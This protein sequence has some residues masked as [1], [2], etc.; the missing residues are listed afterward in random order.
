MIGADGR[1]G[2]NLGEAEEAREGG[3]L[4]ALVEVGV[5]PKLQ[6]WLATVFAPGLRIP[7]P[8][9]GP[10]RSESDSESD[11]GSDSDDN[12]R[13]VSTEAHWTRFALLGADIMVDECGTPWLLEFNHNPALPQLEVSEAARSTSD[14]GEQRVGGAFARHI[15]AM[16]SAA[17]PLLLCGEDGKQYDAIN[18]A[19]ASAID[20]A[21]NED[22]VA[23]RW[24]YVHGP[25]MLAHK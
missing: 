20:L 19:V 17:L 11:S 6:S 7:P 15:A 2:D 3:R 21:K 12:Q 14:S 25:R 9:T 23:G 18:T 8:P 22:S 13:R 16:V 4:R 1:S 24:N 5:L 10:P